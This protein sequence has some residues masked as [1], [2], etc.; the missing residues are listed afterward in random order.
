MHVVSSD[1]LGSDVFNCLKQEG[2]DV[3]LLTSANDVTNCIS[4]PRTPQSGQ[5]GSQGNQSANSAEDGEPVFRKQK[6]D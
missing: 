3:R 6:R 1:R 5:S 4:A 2:V